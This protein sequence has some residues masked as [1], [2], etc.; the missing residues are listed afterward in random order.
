MVHERNLRYFSGRSRE[1]LRCTKAFLS[2]TYFA[3]QLKLNSVFRH[4]VLP[5][6]EDG[7]A[8]EASESVGPTTDMAGDTAFT[9]DKNLT[10]MQKEKNLF[11]DSTH[12]CQ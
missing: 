9:I 1:I 4:L 5:I 3:I 10:V 2:R 12:G 8:E 6:S 7:C 11:S